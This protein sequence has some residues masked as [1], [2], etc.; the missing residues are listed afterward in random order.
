MISVTVIT[1]VII[2]MTNMIMTLTDAFKLFC[3]NN[4][5][6]MLVMLT[7]VVRNLITKIIMAP[8][9]IIIMIKTVV[10]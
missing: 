7:L 5:I 1:L 9:V 10:I 4:V 6:L 2:Q 8:G 3:N